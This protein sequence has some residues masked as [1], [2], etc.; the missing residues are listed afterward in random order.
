MFTVRAKNNSKENKYIQ[1][2]SLNGKALSRCWITHKEIIE[3][4]KL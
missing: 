3:G 2:A 1:S 4:R